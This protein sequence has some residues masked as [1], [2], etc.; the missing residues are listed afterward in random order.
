MRAWGLIFMIAA[1]LT[2]P[3]CN[4]DDHR[5][6]PAARQVGRDA[7]RASEEF[8]EGAKKAEKELR[9]A[10]KDVREGWNEAKHKE[11]PPPK[12]K[13]LSNDPDR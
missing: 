12:K 7:Y 11:E 9:D 5:D 4:R 3:S 2:F 6:E 8:K 10:G 1:G 13:S